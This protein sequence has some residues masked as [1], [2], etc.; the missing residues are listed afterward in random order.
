VEPDTDHPSSGVT[1]PA[2]PGGPFIRP[3]EP[4]ATPT[5]ALRERQV[6]MQWLFVYGLAAFRDGRISFRWFS[7]LARQ[8]PLAMAVRRAMGVSEGLIVQG[9]VEGVSAAQQLHSSDLRE[10]FGGQ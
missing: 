4:R 7:W 10:A 5:V 1:A 3:P 8:I 9:V 2:R 6:L